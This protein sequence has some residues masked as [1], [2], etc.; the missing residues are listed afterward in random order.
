MLSHG[1]VVESGFGPEL[2]LALLTLQGILELKGQRSEGKV[3]VSGPP[4]FLW[5][6]WRNTTRPDVYFY[7]I[8]N[9]SLEDCS[10]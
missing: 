10:A 4:S 9:L 5:L 2:L 3:Y 1:V 8:F 6:G 7:G